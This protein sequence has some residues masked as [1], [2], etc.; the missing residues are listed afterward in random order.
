MHPADDSGPLTG[1]DTAAHLC[2]SGD[3]TQSDIRLRRG[4]FGDHVSY[5]ALFALKQFC[6]SVVAHLLILLA[7]QGCFARYIRRRASTCR[8]PDIWLSAHMISSR[9]EAIAHK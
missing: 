7:W 3:A 9:K 8:S 4:D 2:E 1:D 5:A 6:Q